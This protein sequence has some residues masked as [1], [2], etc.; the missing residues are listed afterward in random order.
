MATLDMHKVGV[1]G[2]GYWGKNLVRN[3]ARLGALAMVCDGA[4]AGRKLAAD[5]APEARVLTDLEELLDAPVD[6]V[7]IA[8]PAETHYLVARQALLAGKDVGREAPGAEL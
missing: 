4:E 6:R 8:T 2:C 3:F 7:V 5:L 1:V